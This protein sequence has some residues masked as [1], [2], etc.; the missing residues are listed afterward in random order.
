MLLSYAPKLLASIAQLEVV[1][2]IEALELLTVLAA[3]TAA[4]AEGTWLSYGFGNER[5]YFISYCFSLHWENNGLLKKENERDKKEKS[6]TYIDF[7]FLNL[8]FWFKLILG[9]SN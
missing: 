3:G 1:V 2:A 9:A 6:L 4:T 8:Q 7:L 5:L